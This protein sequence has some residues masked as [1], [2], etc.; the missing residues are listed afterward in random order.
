MTTPA[1][2]LAPILEAALPNVNVYPAPASSIKAP[3]L[4][5]RP[6]EPWLR[7]GRALGQLTEGWLAIAVAPA[8]D[9]RS[10]MDTLRTTLLVVIDELPDGW[11]LLEVGR[12]LVDESTGSPML[13]A[14][15]RLTYAVG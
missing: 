9:P 7:P 5:L 4:V 14:A 6:D 1:E 3:A 11:A 13:A 12:P 10:A 15:A 8:G 2:E